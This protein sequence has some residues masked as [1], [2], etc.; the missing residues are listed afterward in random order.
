[1]TWLKRHI[2]P[3]IILLVFA[4]IYS[5]ISLVNHY[6]FRTYG[7][8]LGIINQQLYDYAHFRWNRNTVMQPTF[9]NV[10]SDHFTILPML[11]SP[12]YWIGGSYTLLIIQIL[13]ILFGGFGVYM[14]IKLRTD[15]EWLSHFAMLHFFLIWGIYSALGFDYHDNVIAAMFVPWFFYYFYKEKWPASILFFILIMISKENMPLWFFFICL[16][17]TMLNWKDK[18]KVKASAIFGLASIVCFITIVKLIIPALAD[19]G[20]GYVH[21]DYNVLGQDFGDAIVNLIKDPIKYVGIFFTNHTNSPDGVGM[22]EETIAVFLI[23]G[24]LIL[25]RKS[26]YLLMLLP[27]FAQKFFN[28]D[29]GKW[30]LSAQY[31]IEFVPIL[32]IGVF[33]ILSEIKKKWLLYGLSV[34]VI[35]ATGWITKRKIDKRLPAWYN[36]INLQFYKAEHYKAG[37]DR[38]KM[39]EA[40]AKIPKD[41]SV[42]AESNLVPRLAFRKEIYHYPFFTDCEYIIYAPN[43]DQ[44]YPF[45]REQFDAEI[46][47]LLD[48]GKWEVYYENDAARVLRNKEYVPKSQ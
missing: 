28:N 18:K 19:P 37:F 20:R 9:S 34:A 43:D 39:F 14:F 38:D 45:S 1:M 15:N 36:G 12:F 10:L 11:F 8:D 33:E 3:V 22:K 35:I 26:Q 16:G 40:I 17:L 25:F 31:S 48:S 2:W 24:G 42:A 4:G 7:F 47:K 6:N 23:S 29:Y 44:T 30:G 21:F 5:S 32:A 13:A 41:A 46:Q 27:I